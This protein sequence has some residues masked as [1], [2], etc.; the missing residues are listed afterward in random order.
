MIYQPVTMSEKKLP[1]V[2]N[3][4]G[5]FCVEVTSLGLLHDLLKGWTGDLKTFGGSKGRSR[6]LNHLEISA[7]LAVG[8]GC[9]KTSMMEE[10]NPTK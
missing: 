5:N 10:R 9:F 8:E 7:R 6:R 4:P 2:E 3:Q 1:L